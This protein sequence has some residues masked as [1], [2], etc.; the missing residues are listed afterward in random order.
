V[1][2]DQETGKTIKTTGSPGDDPHFG[3][4]K[5]DPSKVVRRSFTAEPPP[6]RPKQ[7]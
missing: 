7:K 6:D 1:A 5:I 4:Q 3:V 2:N